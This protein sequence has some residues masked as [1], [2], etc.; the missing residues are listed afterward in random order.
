MVASFCS[1]RHPSKWHNLSCPTNISINISININISTNISTTNT[2]EINTNTFPRR[3]RTNTTETPPPITATIPSAPT[4][5]P[6]YHPRDVH[7]NWPGQRWSL[8]SISRERG[9][10]KN[11]SSK[12]I[13]SNISISR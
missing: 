10:S 7:K 6:S 12:D 2:Q 13:S 8:P 4:E 1:R 5:G 3:T 11:S 9:G